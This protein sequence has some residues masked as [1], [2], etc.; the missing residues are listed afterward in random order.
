[1]KDVPQV[2]EG[3][4]Q[5]LEDLDATIERLESVYQLDFSKDTIDEALGRERSTQDS[6][7]DIREV[8][9]KDNDVVVVPTSIK[10]IGD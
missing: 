5:V 10:P 4:A 8:S 7:E 2:Q 6:V 1:V 3:H 9:E